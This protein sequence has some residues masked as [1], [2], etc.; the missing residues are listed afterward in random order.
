M[1]RPLSVTDL[2]SALN[3]LTEFSK[4][5][6]TGSGLNITVSSLSGDRT[7]AF[8]I[9]PPIPGDLLHANF[10]YILEALR[11]NLLDTLQLR[12]TAALRDVAS[13][14]KLLTK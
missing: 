1:S 13:I 11:D 6:L 3:V 14:D 4:Q 5:D 9:S 12:K 10:S 8:Y 2:C 7:A